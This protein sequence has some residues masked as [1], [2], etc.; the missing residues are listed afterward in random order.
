MSFESQ[1]LVQESRAAQSSERGSLVSEAYGL[2]SQ[3][4]RGRYDTPQ[5]NGQ[6]AVNQY[7]GSLEL[8]DPD[9]S[10]KTSNSGDVHRFVPGDYDEPG[11]AKAN[12][13][14]HFVPGDY[15]ESGKPTANDV[16][17][18]VPG[19][20]DGLDLPG[21]KVNQPQASEQL[22]NSIT[23]PW[24]RDKQQLEVQQ[25]VTVATAAESLLTGGA[26]SAA[27]QQAV[28]SLLKGGAS[29][30]QDQGLEVQQAAV[31]AA[32][33][34]SFLG[35]EIRLDTAQEA[36]KAMAKALAQ[37]ASERGD[38]GEARVTR[39]PSGRVTEIENPKT[40]KKTELF[41]N[42]NG[43]LGAVSKDGHM[44]A[45]VDGKW[46]DT[47]NDHE[48]KHPINLDFSVDQKTGA[49]WTGN[50]DGWT[51]EYPDGRKE[52][53]GSDPPR[54][55]IEYPN[56]ARVDRWVAGGHILYSPDGTIVSVGQDGRQIIKPGPGAE[57][58]TLP[59]G[60]VQV[61]SRDGHTITVDPDGRTVEEFPDGK[62]ITIFPG[63]N[64]GIVDF[65]PKT[66]IKVPETVLT[67]P[68]KQS[69]KH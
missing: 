69:G 32:A 37:V 30:T 29:S 14:P 13:V 20:Y 4:S 8:F 17:R 12:D 46:Y 24:E 36:A 34:E 7:F 1:D 31:A 45:K 49:I 51:T 50:G 21:M 43:S 10:S 62:E 22:T 11:K 60:Q 47:T 18:F 27:T 19:V 56:G 57:K 40:G 44:Y 68:R 53:F 65:D 2:L 25:A 55:E 58:V 67:A 9:S 64:G 59:N 15:D 3:F 33:A 28:E 66:M 39:D 61:R 26:S 41:Y 48:L 6:S 16:P 35:G 54:S 63:K 42:E 52:S 5:A 23:S 38:S